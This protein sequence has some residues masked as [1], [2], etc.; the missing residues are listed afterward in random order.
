MAIVT[1]CPQCQTAFA[2]QAEHYSAADAWVRCGRCA[3]VFEVDQHLYELD[4]NKP[5]PVT[6]EVPLALRVVP[7]LPPP[8]ALVQPWVLSALSLLLALL[9]CF[10]TLVF[11]R[12]QWRAQSPELTPLLL[13]LCSSLGCEL[14]WPMEPSKVSIETGGFKSLGNH[15]FVFSG[16]IKNQS[17]WPLAT[18]MLE[19]SLTDDVESAVVR[20][21]FSP[22]EL[23]LTKVLRSRRAQ[24]FELIF[25]L[26]PALSPSVLGY[27]AFLFYP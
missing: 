18:P 19:L 22:E 4:D 20:K 10:Q 26:D 25:S 14:N 1:L 12:H 16:S 15:E 13:S 23:G 17:D 9:L 8:Q 5:Q 21:V 3:H 27:R 11:Q 2:I 24:S 7:G 6:V